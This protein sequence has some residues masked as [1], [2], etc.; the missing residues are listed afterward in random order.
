[1]CLDM[2]SEMGSSAEG[3]STGKLYWEWKKIMM[4]EKY[5]L[6]RYLSLAK[7]TCIKLSAIAIVSNRDE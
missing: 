3:I 2:P 6:S 5:L 7:W 1:M 4:F